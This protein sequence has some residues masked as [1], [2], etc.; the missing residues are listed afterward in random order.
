[1]SV[2]K[3]INSVRCAIAEG[4]RVLAASS[5]S[6]RLDAELLL[7][8]AVRQDRTWLYG[9]GED[10]LSD[11]AAD[12]FRTLL[13]ERT[14]GIPIAHLTGS[15]EFWSLEFAVNAHT[16][17]PRPETERLVE[18]ALDRIP[19]NQPCRVLD[20]G[21]GSG[22]IAVTIASERPLADV[23]AT[24]VSADALAIAKENAE[25]HCPGRIRFCPGS[26]FEAV[27]D[28]VYDI[29]VSNPPYIA[30]A[31]TGL[32]DPE[33]AHEPVD[34]L[35]SG[36]DGLDAIRCIVAGAA[37]HLETGGWLLL[38]HGF[39]QADAVTNLLDAAGFDSVDNARDL[40]GLPRVTAGTKP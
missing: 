23:V 13:A 33:L 24:D 37:D 15:R 19:A 22:A 20:L 10:A 35:Y 39:A 17:V 6:A 25:T 8:I 16:L 2:S 5:T 31:E 14:R 30:A 36:A 34:A 12:L 18:L 32:T 4:E 21:T 38:E 28:D 40:A 11:K 26:W 9:H 29:I 1:M 7:A 27:A 3:Q